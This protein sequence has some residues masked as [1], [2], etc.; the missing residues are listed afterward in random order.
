MRNGSVWFQSPKYYQDYK[1][2]PAICDISECAYDFIV[3]VPLE[4]IVGDLPIKVGDVISYEGKE[5]E[6]KEF[7]EP[8]L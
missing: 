7:K 2:S 5:I 8:K 1:G 4:K 6:L 3:E